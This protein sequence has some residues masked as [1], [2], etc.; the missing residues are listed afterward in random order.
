MN[1]I[2]RR[3]SLGKRSNKHGVGHDSVRPRSSRVR[4][5][6]LERRVMLFNPYTHLETGKDVM[7]D[8]ADGTVTIADREYP[9]RDELVAALTE[10][11]NLPF[12]QNGV[13]GDDV[14]DLFMAQSVIHP[15]D[16]GRWVRR[17]Y[18]KAWGAQSDP[19]Y[20]D[21]E[22]SQILAWS[23]GFMIHAAGDVWSHTLVND[24]S[25]G[26]FPALS[27]IP[28][29][30]E[31]LSIALRHTI[32]EMYIADA[33]PG[34][35]GNRSVRTTL[36]DGDISDDSTPGIAMDAPRQFVYETLINP[37][38]PEINAIS[39]DRGF[40]MNYFIDKRAELAAE[41]RPVGEAAR[42]A[43]DDA[44]DSLR[45]IIDQAEELKQDCIDDFDFLACGWDL[46]SLPFDI[47]GDL[48]DAAE[49][50]GHALVGEAWNLVKNAYL[51]AWIDDINDGLKHWSEFGVDLS[52]GFRDPQARRNE[53]NEAD[54]GDELS[55]CGFLQETGSQDGA[56]ATCEAGV[57]IVDVI[58]EEVDDFVVE[59]MLSM[60]GAP[61]WLDEV[62]DALG[63]F[64]QFIDQL[65]NF[66]DPPF[67][68]LRPIVDELKAEAK[69][70]LHDRITEALG[71]DPDV[72]NQILG[73]PAG[74]MD[75]PSIPLGGDT[76]GLFPED[77]HE[78][79][80]TLLGLPDDHHAESLEPLFGVDV[81]GPLLDG[82]DFDKES[83]AAYADAVTLAKLLT[84]DGETMDQ[85]L[86]D[87][88]G[89]ANYRLYETDG[90][91][92]DELGGIGP[93]NPAPGGNVMITALPGLFDDVADPVVRAQWLRVIDGDHAWRSDG[94]GDNEGQP[95]GGG[96]FPLWESCLL[97]DSVF[98]E[99]FRDWENGPE[100]FPDAD[101]SASH[102]PNELP[103]TVNIVGNQ[104]IVVGTPADDHISVSLVQPSG[105]E[106]VLRVQWEGRQ[107]YCAGSQ[108]VPL[109]DVLAP[110][111]IVV[112]AL[113]GNDFVEIELGMISR[114]GTEPYTIPALLYGG[115]G[116]D[117][118]IGGSG[119]DTLSGGIAPPD[120]SQTPGGIPI[121]AGPDDD[122][123]QGRDG[124]DTYLF[125]PGNWLGGDTVDEA[126]GI[127]T[128]TLDFSGG[129]P[130]RLELSMIAPQP[131]SPGHLTLTLT[132][133]SGIENVF[134]SD[135]ADSLTGNS[136]ANVLR[137][138]GGNDL[139]IGAD[140]NDVLT[141]LTGQDILEGGAGDDQLDGGS[142]NDTYR[143]AG[144]LL[145]WDSLIEAAGA[146]TD[147]LDFSAFALPVTVDLTNV[148]AQIVNPGNLVLS[149]SNSTGFENVIG[150]AF[151]DGIR[152]N[153][154]ANVLSGG[155]GND[156]LFGVAGDD[157]LEAGPGD[158]RLV[159]GW[160]NDTFRFAG[161]ILGSD[162][163]DEAAGVNT[164]TLD[165]SNLMAPITIDLGLVV[166]QG[167]PGSLVLRLT[168][169]TGIEDVLGSA[170][171][172]RIRG[173]FR[174]NSIQG[175]NGDD[176]LLGS[177]G[178][179]T[180][181]GGTGHDMLHGE[182]G[183]DVL[184]AGVDG[185][186]D[187]IFG[188]IGRDTFQCNIAERRDFA[189][190]IDDFVATLL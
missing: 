15:H 183:D 4:V 85:V 158:D 47:A 148:A 36:P 28:S 129:W 96:T 76:I 153:S 109:G 88:T 21:Q 61:D 63:D 178:Q 157:S 66:I 24:F 126:P 18:E 89:L 114:A 22:R 71:F 180:L 169:A 39:T 105:G 116:N 82:I 35:D 56:R 58:L 46:V 187:D 140:G 91:L 57:G 179:D 173:N 104:L 92:P 23:Y 5:E 124:D 162:V 64:A 6:V 17:I 138:V 142:N 156:T 72:I 136:R 150:S 90:N 40:L 87:L 190:L 146:N 101:D 41:A 170:F 7:E 2:M 30:S 120:P 163:V 3:L 20:T 151:N 32:V 12:F 93:G 164:D 172:D 49:Q 107:T 184:I 77:A 121:P 95:S 103:P 182:A 117:I 108:E 26:V 68:L 102:D 176:L 33:T 19:Q 55:D 25:E 38:D 161:G 154:R 166:P 132:S 133:A 44:L 100:N 165:F 177:D 10:P 168:N 149:L 119:S 37:D 54:E 51:N 9:V 189:V 137:G 186:I 99:L 42:D 74:M 50:A 167:V 86:R 31:N 80:D 155:N 152:G 130:I 144:A 97:R 98:R 75:L 34:Y 118:L 84:L 111:R 147:T 159:G 139:L 145:G 48:A 60:L 188:E 115:G 141:G 171:A 106:Q 185:L 59:P 122:S 174:N 135:S 83:F 143:F 79:L 11:T 13:V 67:D 160:G 69:D 14:P 78:R 29:D 134:G 175:N 45:D 181:S 128:D 110:Q 53:Q 52:R 70:W 125:F 123:L 8:V 65:D 62:V 1:Q 131:V 94:H 73:S 27:D 16:T 81:S 112:H 113:G 43:L 127:G